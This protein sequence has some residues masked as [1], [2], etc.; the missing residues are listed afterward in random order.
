MRMC[1]NIDVHTT[2][3][4]YMSTLLYVISF[5]NEIQSLVHSA[6]NSLKTIFIAVIRG[7]LRSRTW[8]T[9]IGSYTPLS[10]QTSMCCVSTFIA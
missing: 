5:P 1:I 7:G 3:W 8:N 4:L 2:A 6:H 9:I 10:L